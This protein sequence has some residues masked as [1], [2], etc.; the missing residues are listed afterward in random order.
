MTAVKSEMLRG[1]K[2][3]RVDLPSELVELRSRQRA[4]GRAANELETW[5][6]HERFLRMPGRHEDGRFAKLSSPEGPSVELDL[7]ERTST[8]SGLCGKLNMRRIS[9]NISDR[10]ER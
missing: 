1:R 7:E 8:S 10:D 3:D 2:L 5:T 6:P 4:D 9:E